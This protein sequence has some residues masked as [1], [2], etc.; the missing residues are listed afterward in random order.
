MR[1]RFSR[2]IYLSGMN[3]SPDPVLRHTPLAEWNH[4]P[5]GGS[6]SIGG[7]N[8][9]AATNH[10]HAFPHAAQTHAVNPVRGR[11]LV[12]IEGMAIIGYHQRD[13]ASRSGHRDTYLC[14]VRMADDIR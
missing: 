7:G 4:R 11:Q 1:C 5:N 3:L 6:D 9:E 8:G 14:G 13:S 12:H 10:L 2:G